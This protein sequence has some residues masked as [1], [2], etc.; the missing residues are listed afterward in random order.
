M[1]I[2]VA[3]HY[4]NSVGKEEEEEGGGVCGEINLWAIESPALT[5]SEVHGN[6]AAKL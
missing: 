6:Y 3:G 5:F 4:L 1:K 2:G